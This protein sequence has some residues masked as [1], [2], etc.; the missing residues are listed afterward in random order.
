MELRIWV[1]LALVVGIVFGAF[2]AY[3]A[4]TKHRNGG[5]W[6]LFGFVFN[7]VALLAVIGVPS[8]QAN[9]EN[10]VQH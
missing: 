9:S 10:A 1:G 8:L 4:E 2:C 7:L 6:F 5:T 3:I